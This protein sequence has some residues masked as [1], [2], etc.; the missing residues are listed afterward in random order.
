MAMPQGQD[1]SLNNYSDQYKVMNVRAG[2]KT[3]SLHV[4]RNSKHDFT[5]ARF[6]K[7]VSF[8][9]YQFHV[10]VLIQIQSVP[11]YKILTSVSVTGTQVLDVS[12]YEFLQN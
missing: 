6:W 12:F 1:G 2:E 4:Q 9:S 11:V 10:H 8:I 5:P 7:Q 3:Y